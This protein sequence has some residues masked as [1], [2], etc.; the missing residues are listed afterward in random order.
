M[1]FYSRDEL[2]AIGFRRWG[3]NVLISRKASIYNP[4]A[5]ALGNSVRIDD[6]CVLSAGRE[7]ISI[8]DFVHVAVFSSLIGN[9]HIA[10]DDY[11]NISSRVSIYSSNDDYSG[12][13]LT[14]PMVPAHL[15]GVV[16]APVH[17]GRHVIVGSGTVILPGVTLGD[18]A[19]IGALSLVK[20]DCESFGLYAG[21]PARRLGHRSRD[22]LDL[23]KIHRASLS[24]H[25]GAAPPPA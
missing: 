5:I 11:S 6:F 16:A 21:V 13:R 1:G 15:S 4:H 7:G 17:C 2:S 18:G 10:L 20:H 25:D 24:N 14:S 9:G 22:L 23:E 12:Y 19:A 8:G 3:D